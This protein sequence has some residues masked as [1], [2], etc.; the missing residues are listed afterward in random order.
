MRMTFSDLSDA[1]MFVDAGEPG[2]C[3]AWISRTTG[4]VYVQSDYTDEDEPLPDDIEDAGLYLPIPNK[5]DLGLGRQVAIAFSEEVMPD[6]VEEVRDIFSRR[7]AFRRFRELVE[8]R[9]LL[10]RW[11]EFSNKAE[12]DAL[13]AWCAHKGIE[14]TDNG[15][16][17]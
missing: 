5:R 2:E 17:G 10:Q 16:A 13:R 15:G 4:K 14:L 11:H 3:Q 8:R 6:E 1:F 7:G 12:E 9:R